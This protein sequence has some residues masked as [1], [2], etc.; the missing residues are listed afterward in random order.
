MEQGL[1]RLA[2][3]SGRSTAPG[4]SMYALRVFIVSDSAAPSPC[5][6]MPRRRQNPLK[7]DIDSKT[8]PS[9]SWPLKESRGAVSANRRLTAQ[10]LGSRSL[11]V[12]QRTQHGGDPGLRGRSVRGLYLRT[13]L[14]RRAPEP[15]RGAL[16]IVRCR[17]TCGK[18]TAQRIERDAKSC[19]VGNEQSWPSITNCTTWPV[20][21]QPKQVV[22]LT[23][24]R[25]GRR[26]TSCMSAPGGRAQAA[27]GTGAPA[28]QATPQPATTSA[29]G[30]SRLSASMAI[31]R[32]R[33]A[34]V[35]IG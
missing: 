23:A 1:R 26:S 19:H 32:E 15:G 9:H 25:S 5:G 14:L 24:A 13:G 30:R 27:E 10:V 17:E 22:V 4:A 12:R 34:D 28:A 16:Q 20:L 3:L 31:P 29:N 8:N 33:L 7:D 6:W 21:P 2:S 18:T 35:R 11:G